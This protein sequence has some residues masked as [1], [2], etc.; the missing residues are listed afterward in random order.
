MIFWPRLC[1][2]SVH[3]SPKIV[4]VCNFQGQMLGC[5]YIFC[6]LN[7]LNISLWVTL[8]TQLCLVLYSS[9]ANLQHSLLM[10]LIV[11][12]R[13]LHSIH[14]LFCCVLSILALI[15]LVLTALFCAAIRS[16][17]VSLLMFPFLSQVQAF[18][19][20]MWVFQMPIELFFFP[21]LFPCYYHSVVHRVVSFD[22]DGCNQFFVF[23]D[24]VFESLYRYVNAFFNAGKSSSFL[25]YWYI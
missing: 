19:C 20:E 24:L 7:F 12:S 15:W 25:F 16:D 14:L 5:A 17:S 13:S 6:S 4:Y 10:Q 22:T 3:Q 2:P 11:S 18:S 9:C 1:D 23:F 8:S 21:F